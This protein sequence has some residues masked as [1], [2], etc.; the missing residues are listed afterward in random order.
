MELAQ[1]RIAVISGGAGGIGQATV[2]R[3]VAS[4]FFPIILDRDESS[5]HEILTALRAQGGK[6]EFIA[7]ELTRKREVQDAFNKVI[8][9]Y[10]EVDVL[11]N[12]AGGTLY[13]K[14]IQ[15]FSLP[16]W[17]EIIDANLKS[18]FLCCQAVIGVM[19][20]QQRGT[21]V[22]TSSNYGIT[23]S[24]MHTAYS[25]AKN[26]IIAFMKSLAL[27]LAPYGIRVNCIAP[28]LTATKRVLSHNTAEEMAARVKGIPMGRAGG[29]RDIA[30]GVA[31]LVSEE[32]GYMTGQTLHVNGGMV[33]P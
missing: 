24:R 3:L 12:L 10:N 17:E 28:G 18:T 4:G 27:E 25:A 15:E 21:I 26:A 33:L 13:K 30:E 7:V 5:G 2:L 31:F 23:G 11:V 16:E 32:S 29:A 19:K 6:G 14:L 20:R 1:N 9:R 22:N 8:S